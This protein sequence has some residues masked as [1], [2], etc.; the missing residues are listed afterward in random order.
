M[1]FGLIL[2]V[3]GHLTYMLTIILG[4]DTLHNNMHALADILN[5]FEENT[6]NVKYT[7]TLDNTNNTEET[8]WYDAYKTL[9]DSTNTHNSTK[10]A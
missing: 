7:N 1:Y 6:H 8:I 10:E 9:E 4:S 2:N 3:A 5:T